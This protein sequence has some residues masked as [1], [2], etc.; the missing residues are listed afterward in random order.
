MWFA[1]GY[2]DPSHLDALVP[3]GWKAPALL[4]AQDILPTVVTAS[5]K[6]VLPATTGFE[7]DGT[8]VNHAGYAQTFARAVR[9]PVEV[10][11]ELQLAYDL[12]GRKGLV[13]P[14]A[15]RK[16][17]AAAVKFFANLTSS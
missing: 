6:Y 2:P 17:L 3:S 4:V 1:G 8:F 7:K 5:A 14:T 10:R 13:Q 9:P 15:I 12:L 16:E 11:S